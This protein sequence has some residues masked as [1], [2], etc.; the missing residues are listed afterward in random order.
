VGQINDP[1]QAK[2]YGETAGQKK[3]EGAHG[4]AVQGLDDPIH[5]MLREQATRSSGIKK[6]ARP[7]ERKAG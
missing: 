1:G 3:E 7:K 2:G 4:N 5:E 6:S